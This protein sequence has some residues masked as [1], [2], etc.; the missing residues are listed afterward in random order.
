MTIGSV[1][2]YGTVKRE[3]LYNAAKNCP[4]QDDETVKEIIA[5]GDSEK[6]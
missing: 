4:E 2:Y 6:A 5:K 1:N 3:S